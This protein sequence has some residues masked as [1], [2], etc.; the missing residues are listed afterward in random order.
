MRL[1]LEE[2]DRVARAD[3]RDQERPWSAG[4]AGITTVRPGVCAKYASLDWLW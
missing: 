1:R 4:V 2:H 3:R